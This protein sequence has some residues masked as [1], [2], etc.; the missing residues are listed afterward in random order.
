M[1]KIRF[2]NDNGKMIEF[3]DKEPYILEKF[4]GNDLSGEANS[5]KPPGRDGKKTYSLTRGARRISIECSV[6]STGDSTKWM[7]QTRA[8]NRDIVAQAFDPNYFGTLYYYSHPEDKGKKIRCRPTGLP[9][10]DNDFNNLFKFKIGFESDESVWESAEELSASLGTSFNNHRFPQFMGAA[11]AFA[12]VYSKAEI[13]NDTSYNLFPVIT[14]Y[15]ST[16]P[17]N[18]KNTTTGTY[19]KFKISTGQ[20]HRITIDVKNAS[21][22]REEYI[23]NEWTNQENVIHYLTLDSHLTSF[24]VVPGLNKFTIDT[25]G[26]ESPVLIISANEIVMGV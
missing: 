2:E 11:T 13:T 7:T 1:K 15:N 21:A 6:I 14:V 20:N 12:Y 17:V 8:E 24:I 19:L 10:F 18:V 9:V 16:T 26:E 3:T 23:N 5:I 25:A 4:D 22:V